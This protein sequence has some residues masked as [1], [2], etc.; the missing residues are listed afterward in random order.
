[1]IVSIDSFLFKQRKL[2]WENQFEQTSNNQYIKYIWNNTCTSIFVGFRETWTPCSV[3]YSWIAPKDDMEF[4][5]YIFAKQSNKF[6][7]WEMINIKYWW[8]H[9]NKQKLFHKHATF[10]CVNTSCV[11]KPCDNHLVV[12]TFSQSWFSA[13]DCVRR[14]CIKVTS[15]KGWLHRLATILVFMQIVER[16]GGDK[17]Q[18]KIKQV[19]IIRLPNNFCLNFWDEVKV[20]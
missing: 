15:A 19:Q 16:R 18:K 12:D 1:M 6:C 9:I 3:P 13:Y 10:T 2:R 20:L 5:R 4:M 11:P 14:H 7:L 17:K 8:Y